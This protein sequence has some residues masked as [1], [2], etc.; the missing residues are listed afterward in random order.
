MRVLIL[1]DNPLI[2]LTNSSIN[3]IDQISNNSTNQIYS[4]LCD[5]EISSITIYIQKKNCGLK[6]YKLPYGVSLYKSNDEKVKQQL[7]IR[8][9]DTISKLTKDND[10]ILP[11]KIYITGSGLDELILDK[12][13][14]SIYDFE[15]Y[16]NDKYISSNILYNIELPD[17]LKNKSV[18][19]SFLQFFP[20]FLSLVL[21]S[22]LV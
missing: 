10:E 6:S 5:I 22:S 15:I 12:N 4:I 7:F 16:M 1:L 17:Q 11:E 8:L 3:M 18:L 20:A 19:D 13:S 14:S 9:K 2:A 21:R